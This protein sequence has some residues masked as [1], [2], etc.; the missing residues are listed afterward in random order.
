MPRDSELPTSSDRTLCLDPARLRLSEDGV[1]GFLWPVGLAELTAFRDRLLG[2]LCGLVRGAQARDAAEADLL[3][4]ALP[5]LLYRAMT[6]FEAAAVIERAACRLEVPDR[7]GS[8]GPLLRGE[9]PRDY[10]LDPRRRLR[11]PFPRQPLWRRAARLLRN[12][13]AAS[14]VPRRAAWEID[15]SRGVVAA[16]LQASIP[17]HIAASGER[18]VYCHP[19]DWFPPPGAT[20]ADLRPLDPGLLD[21]TLMAVERATAAFGLALPALASAHLR[22]Y[23]GELTALAR[24]HLE[25]L[26]GK[27]RRLPRRLWLVSGVNPWARVLAMAVQRAGGEVT[28]HEH[29]TGESWAAACGD[30]LF[31]FDTLDRFVC[32][33]E[34]NA[35]R[36]LAQRD[37]GPL[38]R[39][40]GAE[41]VGLPDARTEIARHGGRRAWP[42]QPKVLLVSTLYRADLH[43]RFKP[44]PADIVAADWQARLIGQLRRWGYAPLL[45]PHP[46]QGTGF[47]DGFAEQLAV[48]HIGGS[49]AEAQAQA[50]ILLF[51]LPLTSAI[52]DALRGDKPMVLVDFGQ[53]TP[54]DEARELLERRLPIV[55]GAFDAAN[56]AQVDWEALRAALAA[57]PD[58][59]DPAFFDNYFGGHA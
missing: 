44:A 4:I 40:P 56:R 54:A 35:R 8:L 53:S 37:R 57:A 51:D 10:H 5:G 32:Y 27:P 36:S 43:M 46:E 9:A 15:A 50:D 26:A 25:R 7:S 38:A 23:V 6:L 17:A 45:R 48:P 21:D 55:A 30:S 12:R 41:I 20:S 3:R 1:E 18:A 49:F 19:Q 52:R 28:G 22:G 47:P 58:L 33:T 14:P 2:D 39:H 16:S 24:R 34:G 29:G 59:S 11:A 31:E 42:E 13:V